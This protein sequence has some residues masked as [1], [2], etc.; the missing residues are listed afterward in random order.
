MSDARPIPDNSAVII[1]MLVC[2]DASAEIEF[3]KATFGAIELGRRPG[4]DGSVVHALLKI[5]EAMVMVHGE[6]S[7]LASR[8]PLSD[9]SSPVV[10]YVYVQDVDVVIA[11][12]LAAGARML[13]PIKNQFWGDR[14]GRII[15]P[16]GHVWNVATRIEQTSEAQRKERWST[17]LSPD[18]LEGRA[19]KKK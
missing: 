9:G 19:E 8:A 11:R 5:G 7:S 17:I 3:C 14:V 2:R 1:P 10:L 16:A 15:D 13:L 18:E 12:A 6:F 4:P